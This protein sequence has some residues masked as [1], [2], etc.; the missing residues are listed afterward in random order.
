MQHLYCRPLQRLILSLIFLMNWAWPLVAL[1]AQETPKTQSWWQALLVPLFGVLG[2]ALS[3]FAAYGLL[4][5]IKLIENK[6]KIDVPASIENLMMEKTRWLV[7]SVEEQA[8]N[9]LLYGNGDKT[10]GAQKLND[11]VNEL[12]A[13]VKRWGYDKEWTRLRLEALAQGVLHMERNTT[14]GPRTVP[15]P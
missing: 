5:L 2:T 6:W 4:K 10:P 15:S 14:S 12:E 8:E 11:V 1:A 7:A 9:K 3:S 13:F